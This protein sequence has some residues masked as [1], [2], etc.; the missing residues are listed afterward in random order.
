MSQQF[1]SIS[2]YGDDII[3]PVDE[4]RSLINYLSILGFQTNVDKTYLSGN[5][6][7]SCGGDFL[8]GIDVRPFFLKTRFSFSIVFSFYN[9]L[10]K[11]EVFDRSGSIRKLLLSIIPPTLLLFGPE[12]YGDGHLIDYDIK[13]TPY[14]RKKGWAG[15]IFQTWVSVPLRN[16]EPKCGDSLLPFYL[17]SR[18]KYGEL[19]RVRIHLNPVPGAMTLNSL[20][21]NEQYA[22]ASDPYTLRNT[23]YMA[24]K[25]IKIYVLNY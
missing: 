23:G 8:N 7:E 16:E 10:C 2:V 11:K 5:F 9:F 25:K 19:D 3:V 22:S 4:A 13:L 14:G 17:I 1:H 21:P 12:G 15:S 18:K 24:A 20:Y 6:R